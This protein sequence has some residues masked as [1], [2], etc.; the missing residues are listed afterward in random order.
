MPKSSHSAKATKSV[1][2]VSKPKVIL[3]CD[4]GHD[5]AFAIMFA[6]KH[7]ELLGITSVSGNVGLPL[8]THNA[9]LITQLLNLDAPV[10][11]GAA[12][13]MI[14]VAYHAPDIHGKTGLGGPKLP[15]LTRELA[16]NNAVQ[17][18]IDTVR[19]IDDVWLVAVGPL[20]NVALAIRQAPDIV[21][22]LKGISIMGGSNSFGNRTPAAEFN[23]YADPEAADVVF[24]SGVKTLYM[25][26][27]N[28]THQFRLGMSAVAAMQKMKNNSVA[29]FYGE[30]LEFFLGTYSK[31]FGTLEAPMHDVCAV[32]AVTHPGVIGFE[33]RHV[34]VELRGEHTRGMTLVDER[35][36]Q[37]E[38]LAQNAQVGLSI[39][40]KKGIKLLLDAVARY[41]N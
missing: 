15:K 37:N 13:P 24:S 18:I 4:P 28:L 1:K 20:T 8:T 22:R 41:Q 39:N 27:L 14:G 23:I 38:R 32:L 11:A 30:L 40:R 2:L 36:F 26:G 34:D 35:D 17:F 12:G 21:K 33:P 16:S 31:R 3:D 7:C 6:A 29:S 10:H 9:I 25:C 19:S 5:D